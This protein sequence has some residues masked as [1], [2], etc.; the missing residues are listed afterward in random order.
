MT[1]GHNDRVIPKRTSLTSIAAL[2]VAASLLC[3]NPAGATTVIRAGLPELVERADLVVEG[4]V[5]SAR[6]YVAR[7]E[8]YTDYTLQV[9][10]R[11]KGQ[12]PDTLVVRLPGGAGTV[13][14]GTPK[15]TVG[16]QV[17]LFL[18][19]GNVGDSWVILGL[20][21]GHFELV[22][23][24]YVR[25]LGNVGFI[26]LPYSTGGEDL[27]RIAAPDLRAFLRTQL[28]VRR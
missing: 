16:S 11:F 15:L 8:V 6:E 25:R 4:E 17:L 24:T 5:A 27:T 2:V 21:Q 14:V 28:E 3:A 18:E 7:G 1:S 13:V 10:A 22:E 20:G 23:E 26:D 12:A 9:A 19:R